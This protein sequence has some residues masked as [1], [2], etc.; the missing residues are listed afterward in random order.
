MR[1]GAVTPSVLQNDLTL[2]AQIDSIRLLYLHYISPL[3]KEH[4]LLLKT[5]ATSNRIRRNKTSV[6]E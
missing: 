3:I 2:N 6:L 4:V 5:L 1:K